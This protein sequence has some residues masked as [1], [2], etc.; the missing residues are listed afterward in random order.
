VSTLPR[1]ADEGATAE[2]LRLL[3]AS[4]RERPPEQARL[5]TLLALGVGGPS[6]GSPP[7][8]RAPSAWRGWPLG[9]TGKIAIL[10]VCAGGAIAGAHWFTRARQTSGVAGVS[11][12]PAGAVVAPSTEGPPVA[13]IPP[14]TSPVGAAP[15]GATRDED[16]P[17]RAASKRA[18][19]R[20]AAAPLTPS[21]DTSDTAK[22]PVAESTLSAEVSALER[23]QV[24]LAGR[25]ADGALRA[26][27]RYAVT[28]PA[29][30]LASEATVLRVQA[31]L[32]RGDEASA[33][34]VAD[35]FFTAYPDS[36]Y[37]RRIRELLHDAG[38][39]QKKK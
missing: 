19:H 4:G 8:G 1:W 10:T 3:E 25:D 34:A 28:F 9:A 15:G 5:Q 23:A 6:G 39:R 22:P 35:R 33:G 24:A 2:E 27:D 17:A 32:A 36:S 16:Q 12:P 11:A 38:E 7:S 21:A 20:V 31:L 37:A 18:R 30:R 14:S 29:G 26:L 13:E